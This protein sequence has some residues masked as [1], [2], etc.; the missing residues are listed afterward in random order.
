[1][2]ENS[3]EFTMKKILLALALLVGV[4]TS[5]LAI[6]EGVLYSDDIY[7][8]AVHGWLAPDNFPHSQG[9]VYVVDKE[10]A[11]IL[12]KWNRK[13]DNN[14][15]C[16]P[17]KETGIYT[18][19]SGDEKQEETVKIQQVRTFNQFEIGHFAEGLLDEGKTL[20]LI[21]K[22]DTIFALK[23]P[24]VLEEHIFDIAMKKDVWLFETSK[25]KY[26]LNIEDSFVL[27]DIELVEESIKIINPIFA[28]TS[29]YKCKWS[30]WYYLKGDFSQNEKPNIKFKCTPEE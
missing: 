24:G 26:D 13:K 16:V 3:K 28:V 4:S 21:G 9:Q 30:E 2:L 6:K 29:Q 5:T 10:N 27:H 17:T 8:L 20:P 23:Y 14:L 15:K 1:M 7:M 19:Y 12:L 25:G 18:F 22:N 11:E